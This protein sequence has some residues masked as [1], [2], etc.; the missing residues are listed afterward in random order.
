[1]RKIKWLFSM[2]ALALTIGV[3]S[4]PAGHAAPAAPP[5]LS[6][7]VVSSST[8]IIK[9]ATTKDAWMRQCATLNCGYHVVPRGTTVWSFCA[10]SNVGIYWNFVMTPGDRRT[11]HIDTSVLSAAGINYATCDSAGEAVVPRPSKD[12]WAH[13][14]PAMACG[15]GVIT[16]GHDV[17]GFLTTTDQPE[18]YNWSLVLD[19]HSPNKN[20]VGWVHTIDL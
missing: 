9:S 18:G 11:G 12:L 3:L 2:M 14:C 17:A 5:D 1:M 4:A 16:P 8:T 19:H 20:L 7:A 13:S 15:Y 10:T 6:T